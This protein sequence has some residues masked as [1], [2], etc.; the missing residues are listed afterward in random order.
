LNNG[1]M[2]GLPVLRTMVSKDREL[3]PRAFQVFGPKLV[4]MRG[5]FADPALESRF[6]T[7]ETGAQPLREEVPLHLPDSFRREARALRNQ[8]LAFRLTHFHDCAAAV[9]PRLNGLEPRTQQTALAL[10]SLIDD[11]ELRA[12]IQAHLAAQEASIFADRAQSLEAA[13]V[14]AT[15]AALA[16]SRTQIVLIGEIAQRLNRARAAEAL[17]PL[18]ARA[19]GSLL[20]NRL[21]LRTEKTRGFYGVPA[22]ERSKLE[23]LARRLHVEPP[24]SDMPP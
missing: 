1:T 23:A 9:R 14:S 22:S 20:R 19:V 16:S 17:T 6:L 12:Q 5:A 3:N 21:R 4:G 18:S 2:R 10:L 15:L 11:H 7:E 24:A 13:L 8:L